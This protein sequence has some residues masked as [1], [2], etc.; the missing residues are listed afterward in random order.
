MTAGLYT[1][2]PASI[3]SPSQG[4]WHLGPV[5]LRAYTLAILVGIFV[6][7]WL[8]MRRWAA[9]GGDPDHVLDVAVW[10]VPFGVVGARV[11]HVITDWDKYFGEDGEPAEALRIWEGGLSIWGAIAMGVLGGYIATRRRGLPFPALADALAPGILLAQAIGRWGNYFN[12]ELFGGPTD[13]PWGLEIDADRRPPGYE[14]VETFHPTFLYESLWALAGFLILI[15]ADRRFKLGNGRV[16]ALYVVV[17]TA[18]RTWIETMRIDTGGT[19]EGP[20]REILG[21]RINAWVSLALLVAALLYVVVSTRTRPGREDPFLL[22]PVVEGDGDA[23]DAA[24]EGADDGRAAA[25][26]DVNRSDVGAGAEKGKNTAT[27]K[28]DDE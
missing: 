19:V 12:Q 9:R 14:D 18:G 22:R 15:W 5:P 27:S 2:L 20:A 8:G 24:T 3:P 28:A 10:A 13:L 4:E 1:A 21:M 6:A 23:D 16:F 25:A 11:Y 26:D 17:Y 7:V